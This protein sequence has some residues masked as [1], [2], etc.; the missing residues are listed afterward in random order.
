MPY[1]LK[2]A[3]NTGMSWNYTNKDSHKAILCVQYH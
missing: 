1:Y 2:R 3:G